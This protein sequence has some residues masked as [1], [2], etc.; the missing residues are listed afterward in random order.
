ML[1]VIVW[2]CLLAMAASGQADSKKKVFTNYSFDFSAHRR[3]IAYTTLGNALEH[4]KKV[5]V[6]PAV[7]DRG[8]AYVLDKEITAKEFEVD[9]EFTIR[10]SLD[11]AR[12]FMVL[13]T[14]QPVTEDELM[15]S[16]IGYRQ[17]YEGIG[18]YVFRHPARENKWFAMTLQN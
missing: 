12:G 13:L 5:K 11:Q 6:C 14:Q 2:L 7:A 4:T 10:S 15:A 16:H 1:Q 17:D 9:L 3:P 18:V 8:G